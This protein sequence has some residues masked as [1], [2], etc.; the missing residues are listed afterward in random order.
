MPRS[1]TCKFWRRGFLS[2]YLEGTDEKN[3][4][5]RFYKGVG[6]RPV[7]KFKSVLKKNTTKF[8][9]AW[10]GCLIRNSESCIL[11]GFLAGNIL[12]PVLKYTGDAKNDEAPLIPLVE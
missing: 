11:F 12:P 9:P 4:E 5:A 2:A 8:G 1:S 6:R 3:A 7:E 10:R